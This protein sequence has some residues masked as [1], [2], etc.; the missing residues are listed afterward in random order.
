MISIGERR[1]SNSSHGLG[2]KDTHLSDH[3]PFSLHFVIFSLRQTASGMDIIGEVFA[4]IGCVDHFSL[5]FG[6]EGGFEL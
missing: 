4:E 1:P 3:A 5:A 6:P 2:G